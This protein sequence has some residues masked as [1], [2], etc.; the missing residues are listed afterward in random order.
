MNSLPRPEVTPTVTDRSGGFTAYQQVTIDSAYRAAGVPSR[1]VVRNPRS[2]PGH[3]KFDLVELQVPSAFPNARGTFTVTYSGSDYTIDVDGFTTGTS[4]STYFPSASV[5]AADLQAELIS[6]IGAGWTATYTTSRAQ[7]KIEGPG[8]FSLTFGDAA[9]NDGTGPGYLRIAKALGFEESTTYSSSVV[10]GTD[11]LLSA[12][13]A[14]L[15][16]PSSVLVKFNND[17]VNTHILP[18]FGST[19]YT[20][21]VT[22]NSLS[23]YNNVYKKDSFYPQHLLSH[24]MGDKTAFN[25]YALE[26]IYPNGNLAELHGVNWSL[27]MDIY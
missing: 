4:T 24:A 10:G 12:L 22:L 15:R 17:H 14:D 7:F 1:F 21:V 20:W 5:L 9:N 23:S 8:A 27:R 3:R 18:E 16:Q 6:T 13:S 19:A 11:T 26:L 25:N 2:Y